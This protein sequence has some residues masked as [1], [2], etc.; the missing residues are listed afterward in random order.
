MTAPLVTL[1]N[2]LYCV[3]IHYL[4]KQY[5]TANFLR[6]QHEAPV[7][8]ERESNYEALFIYLFILTQRDCRIKCTVT[9]SYTSS[10]YSSCALRSFKL[11]RGLGGSPG[12]IHHGWTAEQCACCWY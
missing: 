3:I 10:K 8:A 7:V 2:F 4:C 11:G 6:D 5:Q 1:G 12:V 9:E